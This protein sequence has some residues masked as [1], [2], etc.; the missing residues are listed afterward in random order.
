MNPFH[1]EGSGGSGP[2]RLLF[3][4][5]ELRLDSGEL[6]RAGS[7]VKLQPQPAKVLE[8]LA[9]RSGEVVSREEI[10]QL[11]WGDAFVDFD[12]SLNFS[13]KEIRRALGDSATSPTFVETVPRRGYRFLKTV[14]AGPEAGEPPIED[15]SPSLPSPPSLPPRHWSRVGVTLALLLLLALLISG[16]LRPAPSHPRLANLPPPERPVKRPKP[17]QP[18]YEAYLRGIYFQRHEQYEQAAAPLQEAIFRDPGFAPAYAA[19]ALN[20]LHTMST[21][22]DLEAT[23]AAARRALALDPDLADAH[24][25]LGKVLLYHYRDWAGAGRELRAALA[26]DPRSAGAH[27]EYSHYL[28]SLGRQ[29]EAMASVKRA[30]ELD[31]ASM[32]VATDYNWFFYLDHQYEEAIRQGQLILQLYPP[33]A[34]ITPG[35]VREGWRE[36]QFII[37]FSAWKLGDGESG[38]AAAKALLSKVP[39]H[40]QE[41][42][43][44]RSLDD[45]WRGRERRIQ[46]AL[47][48]GPVDLLS[49]AQNAM[50]LGEPER[51]LDLLTHQCEPQGM[52]LPF[53]AVDPIFDDLHSDPRWGQVLDCLKLPADA[54][55]RKALAKGTR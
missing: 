50:F 17:S 54:P 32:L 20:R 29:T 2:P 55:A 16:S 3:D 34:D 21:A 42:E 14:K 11:V 38:L 12:A 26:L 33:S 51:A 35:T 49:R 40:R 18:A 37:L 30:R 9:S 13:V 23:E 22:P 46:D 15:V 27:H 41:A 31:P 43:Q 36:C 25:A 45:Y 44:L 6:L 24:L 48:S 39:G 4:D 8:I 1:P 53:A 47:R 5:F 10:R 7:P 52:E 19:L 28:A